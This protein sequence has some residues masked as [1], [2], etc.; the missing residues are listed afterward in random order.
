VIAGAGDDC[1]I[2]GAPRG[3]EWTLLK[4]DCV[5][6]HVHFLPEAKPEK[7]GWKAMCRAISDIAAMGGE[8]SHALITLAVPRDCAVAWVEGLY[9]G[10]RKAARRFGVAIVGGETAR[11]PGLRFVDVAIQGRVERRCCV[12]RSGGRPGDRLFVTGRL[13]GSQRGRHLDFLPRVAEARWLVRNFSIRAMMDLSDGL[14]ADLP[15]LAQASGCGYEV[16]DSALPVARGA[17]VEA[18]WEEGEDYELLFAVRG[19][20]AKVLGGAWRKAFPKVPLSAIG[21]LTLPGCYQKKSH[22]GFDHFH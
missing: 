1:A 8:P 9:R 13:G 16:E 21:G 22:R 15:R 6:E 11:S 14:G 7:V 4:T 3:A 19:R 20:D 5:I 10:L 18:A 17:S 2:I 12:R